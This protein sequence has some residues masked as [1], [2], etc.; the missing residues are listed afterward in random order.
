MNKIEKELK[1]TSDERAIL[2]NGKIYKKKG[3]GFL[4]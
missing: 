4:L 2:E 1:K 3:F